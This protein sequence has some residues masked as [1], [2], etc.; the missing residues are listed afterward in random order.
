M[1]GL[2][3]CA[4]QAQNPQ[5]PLFPLVAYEKSSS[6]VRIRNVPKKI[7]KWT[8]TSVALAAQYPDNTTK[9]A[10]CVFVGTVWVGTIAGSE[11]VGEG[12]YTIYASGIDENGQPVNDY[13]LGS[14]QVTILAQEV[15]RDANAPVH[16][17]YEEPT[18]EIRE[19]DL[20][21]S[22]ETSAWMIFKDGQS[23]PIVEL[24][25]YYKKSET[26]SAAEISTAFE[27]IDL[28]D[29]YTKDETSAL[30]SNSIS[31]AT[32]PLVLGLDALDHDKRDWDDLKYW[33]WKPGDSVGIE[34]FEIEYDEEDLQL[35]DFTYDKINGSTW[36]ESEDQTYEVYT[37]DFEHFSVRERSTS[38]VLMEF[39]VDNADH[40]EQTF[41]GEVAG[42]T[43]T[44]ILHLK[45]TE[46]ATWDAVEALVGV[47]L[48]SIQY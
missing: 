40:G 7:G 5:N 47:A 28:S 22:G 41:Y 44:V 38:T 18:A 37:R 35:D 42:K 36:R 48:N 25:D 19:G 43:M 1:I 14:G 30:I 27:N 29:Y 24:S 16:M 23:V 13:C 33:Q 15:R 26:S 6:S 32:T 3:D 4:V 2:L 31:S 12:V 9:V 21:Q 11:D 10:N 8:I 46:L 34:K 39:T 45:T 17:L 20:F